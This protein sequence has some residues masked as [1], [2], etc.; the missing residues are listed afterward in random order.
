MSR[1]TRPSNS[2]ESA[3]SSSNLDT[4]I[5]WLSENGLWVIALIISLSVIIYFLKKLKKKHQEIQKLWLFT[6]FFL[7][8]RQMMIPLVVS[9]SRNDK[10]LDPKT[11]TK[12]MEI[13][14]KCR[15]INFKSRPNARLKLEEEVSTILLEYFTRLEEKSQIKPGSKFAKIVHDLEFIDAKLVQLQAVYNQEVEHWNQKLKFPTIK[16]LLKPFGIKVFEK[17]N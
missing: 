9:L 8:K 7:T 12:L 16:V 2:P 4:I 1:P 13:R 5:L 6:L 3:Q 11:Q 14:E 17:F 15:D 10:I